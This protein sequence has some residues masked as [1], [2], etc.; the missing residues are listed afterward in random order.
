MKCCLSTVA[1]TVLAASTGALI[2]GE[3]ERGRKIAHHHCSRCHVIGDYNPNGGI[4][5]TPSF[6]LLVNAL[7]DYKE[8]FD[9]FYVRPPHPA[10]VSIKG[11]EK[12]DNLPYNA[13]PVVISLKDVENILKFAKTLR[14]E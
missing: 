13:E 6:Q 9:T 4:S 2:A 5:S 10:V 3:I 7:P 14:K 11:F 8:R 12:H 1:A